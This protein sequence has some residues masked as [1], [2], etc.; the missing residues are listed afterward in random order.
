MQVPEL[1]GDP[2]FLVP[3]LQQVSGDCPLGSGQQPLK[4]VHTWGRRQDHA[5]RGPCSHS[6]SWKMPVTVTFR[7]SWT[8]KTVSHLQPGQE[9]V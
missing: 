2:A 7:G 6:L 8:R 5:H 3:K 4:P 9:G 1:M